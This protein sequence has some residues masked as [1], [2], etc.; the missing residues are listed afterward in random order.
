M[1][2][3]IDYVA[4]ASTT[5]GGG[6]L[7]IDYLVAGAVVHP[8]PVMDARAHGVLDGAHSV[9]VYW[10]GKH[11]AASLFGTG[12]VFGFNASQCLGWFHY[13]GGEEL[14]RRTRPR[15][16]QAQYRRL[17]L[18]RRCRPSRSAGLRNRSTVRRTSRA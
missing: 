11:K 9:T 4:N 5:M 16:P 14:Y 6:R 10:Y 3:A 2:M 7:K 8:F 17:L 15:H 18:V 12:P 1:S 13:G